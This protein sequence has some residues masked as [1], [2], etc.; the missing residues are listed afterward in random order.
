[1]LNS[2]SNVG[3]KAET[4]GSRPE[5]E[6]RWSK[7]GNRLPASLTRARQNFDRKKR[8]NSPMRRL[9]SSSKPCSSARPF[10]PADGPEDAIMKESIAQRPAISRPIAWR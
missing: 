7:P 10:H 6:N 1:M 4:E 3:S 5:E 8:A 9:R 2:S